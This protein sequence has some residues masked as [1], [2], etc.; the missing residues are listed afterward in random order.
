M[1]FNIE[2]IRFAMVTDIYWTIL[3]LTKATAE[4]HLQSK[5]IEDL[6]GMIRSK[7]TTKGR[8]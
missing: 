4:Q 3:Q 8:W 6:K 2:P 7:S 1:N 5:E